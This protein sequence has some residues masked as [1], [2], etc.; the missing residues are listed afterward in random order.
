MMNIE[1]MEKMILTMRTQAQALNTTADNL[2]LMLTPF[3]Q[4]AQMMES[5]QQGMGAFMKMF[6]IKS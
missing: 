4:Q 3:K 6:Q 5:M 2:E 1:D